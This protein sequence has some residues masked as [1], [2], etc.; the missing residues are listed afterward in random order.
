MKTSYNI[1]SK[2]KAALLGAA[3]SITLAACGSSSGASPAVASGGTAGRSAEGVSGEGAT[4][5]GSD[6]TSVAGGSGSSSATGS[7][8]LTTT[9]NTVGNVAGEVLHVTG[10]TLVGTSDLLAGAGSGTG[11]LGGLVSTVTTGTNQLGTSVQNVGTDVKTDGLGGLPVAGTA[12]GTLTSGVDKAI[13]PLAK[14][15]VLNTTLLG[16]EDPSSKQL[17]NASVLSAAPANN[18]TLGIEAVANRNVLDLKSNNRSL[19][20]NGLLGGGFLGTPGTASGQVSGGAAIG[21]GG[22]LTISR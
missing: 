16:N 4:P 2:F 5:I 10:S 22:L 18:A 14:V 20:G 6:G 15:T 21:L 19:L 9:S 3:I 8:L 17:L 13:D 1:E 11:A 12:I 7:G